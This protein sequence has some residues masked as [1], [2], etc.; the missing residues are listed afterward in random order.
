MQIVETNVWEVVSEAAGR[1]S[2]RYR[3]PAVQRRVIVRVQ[4]E[5]GNEGWGES[6]PLEYFTGETASVSAAVLREAM[7]RLKGRCFE[8]P[9]AVIDELADFSQQ[10]A[11][12]AGLEVALLDLRGKVSG[13]P[14]A[15][16]LGGERRTEISLYGGLGLLPP[17]EAV[18]RAQKCLDQ[19]VSTFK[20]KVGVDLP[21]DAERVLAIREAFQDKVDIRTD[22]NGGY[23]PEEALRFCEKIQDA[24]IEHFEQ[25][26]RPDEKSIFEVFRS[27][28][29]MGV[30]V[31]VDESLSSEENAR[32]LIEEDAVDVGVIKIIKFGGPTS[33]RKV[34]DLFEA[35]GKVPV[36]SSPYESFIGQAAGLALAL[37]LENG[38]KAH[39]FSDPEKGFAEWRHQHIGGRFIREEGAGIGAWGIIERLEALAQSS[40]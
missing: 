4:D 40:V 36:V 12:R 10:H 8:D 24:R 37:T 6:V 34:C 1:R 7:K 27:I 19:G 9:L 23:S 17:Q 32:Q 26:V 13:V 39:E 2:N 28:R 29:G 15:H 30:P 22:A 18:R 20:I 3:A 25:P 5:D 21:A 33:A 38:D 31:A 11:A 16:F 35:A 14:L